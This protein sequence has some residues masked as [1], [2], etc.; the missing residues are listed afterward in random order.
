MHVHILAQGCPEEVPYFTAA[1]NS[2]LTFGDCL[3]FDRQRG[4]F[5]V[6]AERWAT[7]AGAGVGEIMQKV[8]GKM[9]KLQKLQV[10]IA[11]GNIHKGHKRP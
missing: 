10:S 3:L 2:L 9:R 6:C 7:H 1:H 11:W 8:C 4:E 5:V